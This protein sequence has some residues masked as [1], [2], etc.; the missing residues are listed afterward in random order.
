MQRSIFYKG[1]FLFVSFTLLFVALC[2]ALPVHADSTSATTSLN[3]ARLKLVECFQSAKS[4]EAA[5]AN[6]TQLTNMLNDAG[7]LLS[8]AE[9]SYSTGDFSAAE[10]QAIQIHD[11]LSNFVSMA[12]SLQRSAEQNRTADFYIY[13]LGSI[14][15]TVIVVVGS[16]VVW[17]YLKRKSERVGQE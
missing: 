4:A 9:F 14:I 6:I 5:G 15:G 11:S 13:F 12:N 17:F 3:S 7:S 1:V 2:P 10:N 16:I 8:K